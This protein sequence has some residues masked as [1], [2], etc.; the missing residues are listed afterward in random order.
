MLEL[1]AGDLGAFEANGLGVL[2][3]GAAGDVLD[4]SAREELLHAA[5]QFAAIFVMAVVLHGF[6]NW[7]PEASTR[8]EYG[9]DLD[10]ISLI[11]LAVLAHQ[12]Y[13]LLGETLKP[14]NGVI[15]VLS[16]FIVGSGL[17]VG[18][19]FISTAFATDAMEAVSAFGASATGLIP[20][21]VFHVRKLGTW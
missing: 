15:S 17:L 6:Y 18:L 7:A 14:H 8:L 9:Q 11:L 19:G 4:L 16:I 20:I 10:L 3:L 2:E 21:A 5:G 1:D 12:F 13:A